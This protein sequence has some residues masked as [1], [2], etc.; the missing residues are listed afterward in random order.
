MEYRNYSYSLN[1]L[2][3]VFGTI[4]ELWRLRLQRPTTDFVKQRLISTKGE[5]SSTEKGL[6]LS[7]L[8][9]PILA[10]TKSFRLLKQT[11]SESKLCDCA[12]F[13]INSGYDP[14]KTLT[15]HMLPQNQII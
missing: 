10:T 3:S 14:T 6:L 8:N 9:H 11:L 13:G 15:Q 4:L 1:D 12:I 5:P 7:P 2:D